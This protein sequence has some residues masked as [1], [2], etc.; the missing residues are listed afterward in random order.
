M[1]T[2]RSHRCATGQSLVVGAALSTILVYA[3]IGDAATLYVAPDGQIQWSGGLSEPNADR[4]DGPLPSIEAARDRIRSRRAKGDWL[5]EEITVYLRG[6]MYVLGEPVVFGPQDSGTAARPVVYAAFK[7]EAP[8]ISGG[9]VIRGWRTV[10]L[11]G[12]SVWAVEI[13]EVK[14]GP[15]SRIRHRGSQ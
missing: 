13:P 15:P 6:G 7:Q 2:S 4:S 10:E 9:R 11:H 1:T 14:Q 8:I 3:C 12:K 5:K